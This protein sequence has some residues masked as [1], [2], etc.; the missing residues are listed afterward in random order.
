MIF[1]KGNF[2]K[3]RIQKRWAVTTLAEKCGISRSSIT[4]WE[5]GKLEPSEKMVRIM[6]QFLQVPVSEISSLSEEQPKSQHLISG[7]ADS[8][9]SFAEEHSGFYDR[10]IDT[11]YKTVHTLDKKIK[12]TAIIT[13]ALLSSM[14]IC[15]YIKDTN[16]KYVIANKKLLRNLSLPVD[17]NILG[18]T[19]K[20]VFSYKEAKNNYEEDLDVLRTGEP[21]L[22]HE[23][24]IPG[25]RKKKWGLISKIP[26]LDTNECVSGVIGT[27]VDITDRKKEEKKRKILEEAIN[28]LNDGVIIWKNPEKRIDTAEIVFINN[29]IKKITGINIK[30]TFT[31]RSFLNVVHKD[32]HALFTN[33]L[34]NA[35]SENRSYYEF[36]I[37]NRMT[38]KESIL[39]GKIFQYEKD[40][41]IGLFRDITD[42]IRKNEIREMLEQA[43]YNSKDVVW[44]SRLE[45]AYKVIYISKSVFELFG[46]PPE[47]FYNDKDFWY[48]NCCHPDDVEELV[49]YRDDMRWPSKKEHRIIRKDGQVR[50]I[51]TSVTP[52][53]VR[54]KQCVFYIDRDITERKKAEKDRE[55]LEELMK[56]SPYIFWVCE[57][58]PSSR[59]I[60]VSDSIKDIYGY[61]ASDFLDKYDFWIS[62]CVHKDDRE[63]CRDAFFVNND[64]INKLRC[65]IVRPDGS[66]RHVETTIINRRENYIAYVEKDITHE[67]NKAEEIESAKILTIAKKLLKGG[68]DVDTISSC[69]GLDKK[70]ILNS[71][72]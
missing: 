55:L 47:T 42:E 70:M 44:Y 6:A 16:S 41:Y 43:L 11:L 65:R 56:D 23:S 39:R 57:S 67:V 9:L 33:A 10:N 60:F 48:N 61:E 64:K 27:F 45:P 8:Y 29:G 3:I 31:I 24:Y 21:V 53:K 18:R 20:D 32:D 1:K 14:D 34:F 50:W 22:K 7:V 4:R 62:N 51:E 66:I 35:D 52:K 69:T 36:R 58:A 59:N 5:T 68:I 46:Y 12:E 19:D 54:G 38:N 63:K 37:I 72:S 13:K 15:F 28:D 30:D 17:Y 49:N 26:I 71:I 40:S 25:T 2:K